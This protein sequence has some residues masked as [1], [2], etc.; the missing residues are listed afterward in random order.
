MKKL[1]FP[2]LIICLVLGLGIYYVSTEYNKKHEQSNNG[3]NNQSSEEAV[4]EEDLRYESDGILMDIDKEKKT[5]RFRAV[6]GGKDFVLDYDGTSV[7]LSKHGKSMTLDQFRLGDVVTAEYSIRTGKLYRMQMSS[8]TWVQTDVVRFSLDETRG[9]ATIADE[10]YKVIDNPIISFGDTLVESKDIAEG[11]T[12]TV[13]GCDRTVLSVIVNEG[14]GYL[15]LKNDEYFVGGWIEVGQEII[16]PITEGMV[17]PVPEGDYHVRLTNRGYAGEEDISI[18]RNEETEIDL[19]DIEIEEVAIGHIKFDIIPSYALL[20][21]DGQMVEY[22]DRIAL[23]Y[24]VHK[25][26]VEAS[27][28]ETIENNI[29]VSGEYAD[30][31]IELDSKEDEEDEDSD[32]KDEKET[33]TPTPTPAE[34]VTPTPVPTVSVTLNPTSS[35]LFGGTSSSGVVPTMP[36]VQS[37]SSS[38]MLNADSSETVISDTRKIHIDAPFGVNVYLDDAYIGVAPVSTPKVTGTHSVTLAKEGYNTKKYTVHIANDDN[39]VTFSFS[40]LEISQ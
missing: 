10:T 9:I 8:N 21:V 37:T 11:D 38:M 29:R 5:L 39:D 34:S 23:E 25:I 30:I 4:S 26:K 14:H 3:Q 6:D 33:P 28:Y 35:D 40:D 16:T 1:I 2:I 31:S 18:V 27:G 32:G 13:T 19:S 17:L 20:Y 7:M 12:L 15:R 22:D 36:L 24:G